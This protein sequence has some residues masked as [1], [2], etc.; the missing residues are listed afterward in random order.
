MKPIIGKTNTSPFGGG[1]RGRTIL[2][3]KN[4]WGGPSSTKKG[5]MRNIN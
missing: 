3:K 4:R 5:G 1:T 2:T